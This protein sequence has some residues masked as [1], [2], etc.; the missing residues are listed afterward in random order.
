M[1]HDLTIHDGIARFADNERSGPAWH[2]LCQQIL[3]NQNASEAWGRIGQG[4]TYRKL[5]LSV[6]GKS[7]YCAY[8][9]YYGLCSIVAGHH[10]G[11]EVVN[12]HTLYS[13]GT[14]QSGYVPLFAPATVQVIDK[15]SGGMAVD[16]LGLLG[17]SGH[18]LFCSL[19]LPH[20]EVAGDE[21]AGY[22]NIGAPMNGTEAVWARTGAV[23]MVCAN[24]MAMAMAEHTDHAFSSRHY[25]NIAQRLEEWLRA[26]LSQQG[27]VLETIKEACTLLALASCSQATLKAGVLWTVY[28]YPNRPEEPKL[29]EP[30]EKACLKLADRRTAVSHL[31]DSS[32]T[33]TPATTGTLWGAYQ[34]VVEYEDYYRPR[35]TAMSKVFGVGKE[36]KEAAFTACMSLV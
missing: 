10:E 3:D 25:S 2:G 24:T 7:G 13:L 21:I 15:A 20:F 9:G 18:T 19:A 22:L 36:R 28:P 34:A 4:I 6:K 8:P 1:A 30:W 14:V 5:P 33:R 31:F 27:Q 17:K 16:T 11:G 35:A 12:G 29:V 26:I 32:P 23:R